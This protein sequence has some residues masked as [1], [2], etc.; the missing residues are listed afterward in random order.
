MKSVLRFQKHH[1]H[2][3]WLVGRLLRFRLCT[4]ATEKFPP[5]LPKVP[6]S[7]NDMAAFFCCLRCTEANDLLLMTANF[8]WYSD[9]AFTDMPYWKHVSSIFY[10]GDFLQQSFGCYFKS[11]LLVLFCPPRIFFHSSVLLCFAFMNGLSF[12]HIFQKGQRIVCSELQA[13]HLLSH[14]SNVLQLFMSEVSRLLTHSLLEAVG[15]IQFCVISTNLVCFMGY[16]LN[17]QANSLMCFIDQRKLS[18]ACTSCLFVAFTWRKRPRHD[19]LSEPR[20]SILSF[21]FSSLIFPSQR[22]F[23]STNTYFSK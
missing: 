1:R 7:T 6:V 17:R 13:F 8:T 12:E 18:L 19:G 14:T 21:S 5:Q 9:W 16:L 23:L 22:S 2:S 4:E 20:Y 15:I 10:W 11:G 3:Q